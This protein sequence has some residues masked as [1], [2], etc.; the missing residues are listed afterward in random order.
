M[1]RLRGNLQRPG[2]RKAKFRGSKE[3]NVVKTHTVDVCCMTPNQKVQK[4]IGGWPWGDWGTRVGRHLVGIWFCAPGTQETIQKRERE[5]VAIMNPIIHSKH[6]VSIYK[7]PGVVT[8]SGNSEVNPVIVHPC[9]PGIYSLQRT[10]DT[11][12][13]LREGKNYRFYYAIVSRAHGVVS[14]LWEKLIC[15]SA[16][17]LYSRGP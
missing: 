13:E 5:K 3:S 17:K 10:Q 2:E 9:L 16:L 6:L 12:K 8:G 11:Y 15:C 14:S 7:V 1:P 4:D